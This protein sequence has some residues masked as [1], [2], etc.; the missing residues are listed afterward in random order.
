MAKKKTAKKPTGSAPAAE[1]AAKKPG[2]FGFIA[3]AIRAAMEAN[4][5]ASVTELQ[6]K[7][8]EQYPTEG[9]D[10]KYNMIYSMK[11]KGGKKAKAS[12]AGNGKNAKSNV[13]VTVD[14]GSS[15]EMAAVI[16]L[17]KAGS[18]EAAKATL[19]MIG[20]VADVFRKGKAPF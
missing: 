9:F 1:G 15:K 3:S 12:G 13:G 18:L 2:D 20:A 19:E 7:L 11:K 14:L 10:K 6:A 8:V 17:Q 5:K 16:L 4:P